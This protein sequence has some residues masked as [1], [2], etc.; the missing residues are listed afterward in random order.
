MELL[1]YLDHPSSPLPLLCW[2]VPMDVASSVLGAMYTTVLTRKVI[3]IEGANSTASLSSG[4][5]GRDHALSLCVPVAFT[6]LAPLLHLVASYSLAR[7]R[8]TQPN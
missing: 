8:N 1:S 2:Q 6:M 4:L 7:R 3:E 5:T